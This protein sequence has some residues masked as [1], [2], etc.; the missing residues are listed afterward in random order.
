M[1]LTGL[2][3]SDRT[4][5]VAVGGGLSDIFPIKQGASQGSCL[6][7]LLYTVYISKLHEIVRR[8]LPSLH[9]YVND[10]QLYIA[11]SPNTPG[12]AESLKSRLKLCVTVL[13]YG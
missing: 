7:K 9:C 3:L 12:D 10:T 4:Q 11:F 6:G 2:H 1:R 13:Y 5:R 8:H